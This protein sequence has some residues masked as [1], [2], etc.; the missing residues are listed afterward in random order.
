MT[1]RQVAASPT[2]VRVGCGHWSNPNKDYLN[3]QHDD[4]LAPKRQR[5]IGECLARL[6]RFGATK[7]ALE[8][9]ADRAD[10]L[11]E[12]YRR[13]RTGAFALTAN[14]RHQLGFRL[15]AE[16]GHDR[17]YAINWHDLTRTIGWDDAF[18]FARAHDQ[19]DLIGLGADHERDRRRAM[20]DERARTRALT[21]LD[22]LREANDPENLRQSHRTYADLMRVGAD[23]D[24]V[25]ADDDYVG[26]D[27]VGRWY[28]RNMKMF[29]NLGRLTDAADDR[30]L[31][32]VGAGHV[33]LLSPFVEGSGRYALESVRTYLD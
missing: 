21:V 22:M 20:D 26:A 18:A 8:V 14:E 15:A 17:I 3:V 1:A 5:E 24:Y 23:D 19:L 28:E 33:P 11:N 25:G 9:M 27:V 31:V 7:V 32:V 29:V 30:I 4:M 12:D 16:L 10:E 6:K 2:V 13:Y